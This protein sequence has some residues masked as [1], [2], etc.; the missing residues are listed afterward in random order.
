MHIL[1]SADHRLSATSSSNPARH[2][3]FQQHCTTAP[4]PTVR[5]L[6]TQEGA[7]RLALPLAQTPSH[8]LPYLNHSPCPPPQPGAWPTFLP[9]PGSASGPPWGARGGPAASLARALPPGPQPCTSGVG[10]WAQ[11]YRTLLLPCSACLPALGLRNFPE[12]QGEGD[13]A[14]RTSGPPREAHPRRRKKM[15]EPSIPQ[16][17][18]ANARSAR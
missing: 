4:G 12:R 1:N 2:P 5:G 9:P 17:D 16:S 15:A 10:W 3:D 13:S 6:P 11:P 7:G 18:S 8:A 14:N